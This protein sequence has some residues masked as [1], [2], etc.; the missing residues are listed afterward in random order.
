HH[1][2]ADE[3]RSFALRNDHRGNPRCNKITRSNEDPDVRPLII[4]DGHLIGRQRGP[5]DCVSSTPPLHPRWTPLL[6]GDPA[7][8]QLIVIYPATIVIRHPSPIRL[9]FVFDPIPTPVIGVDPV[10]RRV[11]LPF[12]RPVPGNPDVAPARVALPAA[13]RFQ[14]C[15]ELNGY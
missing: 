5:A 1:G 10:S 8:L 3:D 2:L 11:G 14:R 15:L 12:A 7:P 4:V 9:R 13:M 6:A